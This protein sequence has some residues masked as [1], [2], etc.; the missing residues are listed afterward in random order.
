MTGWENDP[1]GIVQKIEFWHYY[2]IVCAQTII[3]PIHK[4][5]KEFKIKM[6]Y[7]ILMRRPDL[8]QINEKKKTSR[9][10]HSSWLLS[11]NQRKWKDRQILGPCQRTEKLWN[12]HG[13]VRVA[14]GML[15]TVPQRDWNDWKSEKISIS[16]RLQHCWDQ[17]EY[18]KES[19]KPEESCC[20]SDSSESLPANTSMKNSQDMK[21]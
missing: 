17:Q 18:W 21:Q 19:R 5:L 20:H 8:V 14:I 15:G 6:N 11:E 2:Q 3:H 10:C 16:S 7:L 1:Q 9:F 4:I 12:I 13:R